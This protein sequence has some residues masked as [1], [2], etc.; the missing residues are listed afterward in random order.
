MISLSRSKE[1]SL[2]EKFL[3]LG[4]SPLAVVVV[5]KELAGVNFSAEF[6][7]LAF[8]VAVDAASYLSNCL[9]SMSTE[10]LLG[11]PTYMFCAFSLL[12]LA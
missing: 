3:A 2:S 5:V 10:I 9:F 12:S 11:S 4:E 6:D 1:S 7:L 8:G